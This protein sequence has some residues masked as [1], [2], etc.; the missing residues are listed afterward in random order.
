MYRTRVRWRRLSVTVAVAV[1]VA[2]L[3][4][5][6]AGAGAAR[7]PVFRTHVVEP[8][9]TLWEIAEAI[10]G[11]EVDPRPVVYRLVEVNRLPGGA[12]RAGQRLLLPAEGW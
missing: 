7:E 3:V 4:V 12:I 2:F 5:G 1:S 8:G 11:P 6:R 9:E 10:V